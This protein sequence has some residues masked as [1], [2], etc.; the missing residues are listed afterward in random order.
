MK[1]NTLTFI[2]LMVST[3]GFAQSSIFNDSTAVFYV[4][5]SYGFYTNSGTIAM[6]SSPNIEI[7]WQWN[8]LSLGLDVG[9]THLGQ[10]T[11]RDT[12]TYFEIRPNLN[13]FQ[14]GKFTNTLTFGIG[15]VPNA[16]ENI[17][18]ESNA[19]I[20]FSPT[21]QWSLNLFYGTYY[22][23]G[24]ES[25]RNQ[26]YIGFSTIYFFLPKKKKGIFNK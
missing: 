4:S 2:M 21:P 15:Y 9:K 25:A 18:I 23:S 11:G 6:R 22:F 16:R 8:S 26:T 3:L 14:Q 12:T 10:K 19:G 24:V 17:L 20:Q 7:G 1:K 13:V 5:P